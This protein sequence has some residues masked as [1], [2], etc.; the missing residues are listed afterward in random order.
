MLFLYHSIQWGESDATVGFNAGDRERSF[1]LT[2]RFTASIDFDSSSNV[3]IPGLYIFRVDQ[4]EIIV[5]Q[6]ILCTC[7]V[8]INTAPTLE[9]TQSFKC[10]CGSHR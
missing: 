3:G 8:Q 2:D 5:P 10:M 6:G 7:T 4:D 9:V 1:T